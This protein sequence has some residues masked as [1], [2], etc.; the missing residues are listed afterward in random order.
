MKP[1][2]TDHLIIA[3][4][5]HLLSA[6]TIILTNPENYILET[7][8]PENYANSILSAFELFPAIGHYRGPTYTGK[9]K[10]ETDFNFTSYPDIP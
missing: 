1:T 10:P 7:D 4:R 5:H 6:L 2:F 8:T 9:P 3:H